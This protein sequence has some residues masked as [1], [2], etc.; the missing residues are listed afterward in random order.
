MFSLNV[1]VNVLL[2]GNKL[3]CPLDNL[4]AAALA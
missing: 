2:M 3:V 4:S 1:V